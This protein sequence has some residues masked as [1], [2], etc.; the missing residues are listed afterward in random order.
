MKTEAKIGIIMPYFGRKWPAYLDLY[1]KSCAYNPSV[2]VLFFTDIPFPDSYP[3]NVKFYRFTLT[4]LRRLI[5]EKL[6][7]STSIDT[8]FKLC[9]IRPAYGLLFQEYISEYNFWGHGDI[10]LVYGDIRKFITN[11]LLRRYDVISCREKWISGALSLFRNNEVINSLFLTSGDYKKVFTD[12]KYYGFDECSKAWN[13]VRTSTSILDVNLHTTNMTQ[14]VRKKEEKREISTFFSNIIKEFILPNESVK[15]ENGRVTSDEQEYLLYHY[16]SEKRRK[17]FYFPKLEEVPDKF[18]ITTT[19]YF[20]EAQFNHT[21]FPLAT[22]AR[23]IKGQC[24]EGYQLL[25][26]A[27]KKLSLGL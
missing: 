10:D 6:D 15:W 12:N 27:R 16:V 9:D 5:K 1:L 14:L 8:G 20:S 11:N 23:K 18:Y 4:D 21:L 26:K 3:A 13:L 19:G 7:L 2:D 25:N 22:S 24:L 17:Y